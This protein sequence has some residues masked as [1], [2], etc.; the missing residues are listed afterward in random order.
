VALHPKGGRL[1]PQ[2]AR[3]RL[4]SSAE[5]SQAS[6]CVL[7]TGTTPVSHFAEYRKRADECRRLAAKAADSRVRDELV[8]MATIWTKIADDHERRSAGKVD[9]PAPI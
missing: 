5:T 6:V 4:T 8:K 9:D 2:V 3:R 1:E 7:A